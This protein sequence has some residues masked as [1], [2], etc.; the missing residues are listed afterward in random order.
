MVK[1]PINVPVNHGKFT[2]KIRKKALLILEKEHFLTAAC[3][4]GPKSHCIVSHR[5]SS[6]F[7]FVICLH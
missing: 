7:C 4:V 5:N 3:G 2:F 6:A 1:V